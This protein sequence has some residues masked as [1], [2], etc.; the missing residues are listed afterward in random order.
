MKNLRNKLI[1]DMDEFERMDLEDMDENIF[2]DT[3]AVLLE[4][5]TKLW[6]EE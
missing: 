2:M 6:G 4:N 5:L 1:D 3:D